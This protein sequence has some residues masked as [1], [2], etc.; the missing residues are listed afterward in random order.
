MDDINWRAARVTLYLYSVFSNRP[1]RSG[2]LSERV[3]PV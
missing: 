1:T 3:I 2:N